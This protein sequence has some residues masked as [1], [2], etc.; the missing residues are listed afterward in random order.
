[1]FKQQYWRE[2]TRL[3]DYADPVTQRELVKAARDANIPKVQID[4]MIQRM[5]PLTR[6]PARGTIDAAE[7]AGR[8]SNIGDGRFV[9]SAEEADMIAKEYALRQVNTLLYQ[10]TE[11]GQTLASMRLIFPFGEAWKEIGLTWSRLMA[12]SPHNLRRGQI[13]LDGARA[14]GFLYVDPITGEESYTSPGPGLLTKG[15]LLGI[16]LFEPLPEGTRAIGTSPIQGVN[17]FAGS[18]IPGIGPVFN[19]VLGSALP[20]NT[21]AARDLRNFLLPF[22]SLTHDVSDLVNPDTY[23]NI[24]WPAWMKKAFTAV[25]EDGFDSRMWRSHVADSVRVLSASGEYGTSEEEIR[26]L[27]DDA[28]ALAK[29]TLWFRAIGQAILPTGYRVDFQIARF[30]SGSCRA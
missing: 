30:G 4:D 28:E 1:V 13:Y 11:R 10:L 18:A 3:M 2:I 22:G 19:M 5:L 6:L 15:S 20:D 12:S 9:R 25:L 29:R 14:N 21:E 23:L 16:P 24:I 27:S 7:A 17:L 26:R 8:V